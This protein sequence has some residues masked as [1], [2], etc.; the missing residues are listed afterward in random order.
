MN[1][2]KV[3]EH[4]LDRTTEKFYEDG[5]VSFTMDDVARDSGI[6]K[7]TLYRLIPSRQD[8]IFRVVNRQMDRVKAKQQEILADTSLDYRQKLDALIGTVSG[9]LSRVQRRSMQEMGRIHP[10]LWE[11]IRMRRMEILK[12]MSAVLEEGLADG[13]VRTDIPVDF[14]ARYFQ[15]VV[16][17]MIT[18]RTIGD[19]QMAPRELMSSV[20]N[21]FF[22]GIS[23]DGGTPERFRDSQP[24]ASIQHEE[25]FH[26]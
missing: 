2:E 22:D 26:D 3:T 18:P 21:L 12:G 1:D 16:D 5:F 23:L 6:S 8:L 7:K 15:S 10:D 17:S 24:G 20:L 19:V 9:I 13:R 25:L 14:I 4:I 11:M